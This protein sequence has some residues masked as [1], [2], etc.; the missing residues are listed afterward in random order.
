MIGEIIVLARQIFPRSASTHQ[1]GWEKSAVGSSRELQGKTLGIVGYGNIR[2]A[3]QCS[4]RKHGDGGALFR[5]FQSVAPGE[6]WIDGVARRAPRNLGLCD[7]ARS[8]TASTQNM[9]GRSRTA[10]MKKGAIFINNSRGTVVGLDTL[11]TVLKE[12]HLA[13]AAVDVFPVEPASNKDASDRRFRVPGNVILTPHIGG[14]TEEAQERIGRRVS[15]KLVEYSDVGSFDG[16]G[17]FSSGSAAQLRP[18]SRGSSTSMKTAP[19]RS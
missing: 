9:I 10:R 11:A 17:Q 8:E 12:G 13:G 4:C 15:R 19:V 1:G 14:S 3:A 16:R 18:D 2:F 5:P 7:D 6:D